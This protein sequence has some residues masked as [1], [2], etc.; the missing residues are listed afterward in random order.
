[1]TDGLYF[2]GVLINQSSSLDEPAPTVMS[3]GMGGVG[4]YQARL[5]YGEEEHR[6]GMS[7]N[8]GGKPP[9][10]VPSMGEIDKIKKNG[11][12][13]IS[14]FT[15]AGGSCLG[16][17]MAGFE[18]IWAS[19]FVPAAQE[20][21]ELNFPGVPVNTGDIRD[22]SPK[23]LLDE[24]GISAGEADV[25]EG[26]PPCASF[27]TAGKREKFWGEKVSY[28]ETTQRVDDLFFE[29]V[30]ILEGVQP[31]V[32]VAE[33]VSGLIKGKSKGYFKEIIRAMKKAGYEVSAKL[34][35]AQWLG[36][37]QMRQRVIFVGVRKDLKLEP[38]HPKPLPY[39]YSVRDALP[40]IEHVGLHKPGTYEPEFVDSQEQ[41]APT[42]QTRKM[43]G[44]GL[45]ASSGDDGNLFVIEEDGRYIDPETG[46]VIS[47][48][49][50]AI[51]K[52]WDHL[53]PGQT[54]EIYFNLRRLATDKPSSTITQTAGSVGAAGVTHPIHKRKLTLGELRR[55]CSFP[56]D[57][58][59]TG[60]YSQR[61]ERLGRAVPPLMMRAVAEVIRDEI[62]ANI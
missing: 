18:T 55:L 31:K 10:A 29:Y 22:L 2:E 57:F 32:F 37:P 44:A 21:Y 48:D 27:S 12:K 38:A 41:A 23:D 47:I 43:G 56:D 16:F 50:T 42:I 26:S 61:W 20:V 34:L 33:N 36:V 8:D 58:Q 30:R 46:H 4:M 35:D 40:W 59:L 19:E 5:V 45:V 25:M 17:K 39:R 7:S 53:I 60:S 52:E 9:Y 51:G 28:S 1:M 13:V 54:S 49:E 15:G 6:I 11:L 24:A 62:L 14:T 3:V